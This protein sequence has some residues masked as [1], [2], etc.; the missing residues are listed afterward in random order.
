MLA[1]IRA[2]PPGDATRAAGVQA[3]AACYG[4]QTQHLAVRLNFPLQQA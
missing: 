3:L 1:A 4:V 2:H